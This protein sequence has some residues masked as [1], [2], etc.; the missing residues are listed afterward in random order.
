MVAHALGHGHGPAVAHTKALARQSGHIRL[1]AGG[2]VQR[3][4]ADQRVVRIPFSL[5]GRANRQ[6]S[7]G[8]P[9]A[10][11]VVG[12]AV[13]GDLLALAQK[14]PEGLAAAAAHRKGLIA[15]EHGSEGPVG[16]QKRPPGVGKL[17]I[18]PL[19]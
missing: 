19:A 17:H 11:I 5:L 9:L 18:R 12:F 10:E 3:H 2:P 4:I 15:L 6:D 16:V 7:A 1:A 13:K 8:K 14:R